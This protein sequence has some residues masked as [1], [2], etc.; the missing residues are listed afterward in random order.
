MPQHIRGFGQ[1]SRAD[2]A[3]LRPR[4]DQ[5]KRDAPGPVNR[6]KAHRA[7]AGFCNQT[8]G[9]CGD[10]CPQDWPGWQH[11]RCPHFLDPWAVSGRQIRPDLDAHTGH[12]AIG[13]H[14][15]HLAKASERQREAAVNRPPATLRQRAL[16]LDQA[17]ISAESRMPAQLNQPLA[18]DRIGWRAVSRGRERST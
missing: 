14:L 6:R 8:V 4:L 13:Q 1:Q 18:E 10:A 17:P 7:R 2:A 16:R 5:D 11:R 9:K 12:A 15:V 3:P